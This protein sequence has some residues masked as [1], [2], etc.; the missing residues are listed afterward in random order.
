MQSHPKMVTVQHVGAFALWQQNMLP[1]GSAV[2]QCQWHHAVPTA[3][4]AV[5]DTPPVKSLL[6]NC[7]PTNYVPS[8]LATAPPS[9]PSSRTFELSSRAATVDPE[10]PIGYGSFGVVWSVFCQ[11]R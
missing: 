3:P 11:T 2:V 5:F 1:Y 8:Q 4:T 7:T 6:N 10:Q 9:H